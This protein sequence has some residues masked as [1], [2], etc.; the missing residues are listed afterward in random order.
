MKSTILR[1][2]NNIRLPPSHYYNVIINLLLQVWGVSQWA[3]AGW[4]PVQPTQSRWVVHCRG[5]TSCRKK[6]PAWLWADV[7]PRPEWKPSQAAKE[8]GALQMKLYL[9]GG[10]SPPSG[11][12]GDAFAVAMGWTVSMAWVKSSRWIWR[13]GRLLPCASHLKRSPPSAV[14]RAG[15][16]L[17]RQIGSASFV[18]QLSGGQSSSSSSH[19]Q[20]QMSILFVWTGCSHLSGLRCLT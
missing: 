15:T 2:P 1:T 9:R 12:R 5:R 6:I 13:P 4:S 14:S 16:A 8:A 10:P 20:L 17:G 7:R 19:Y 18:T 3:R 11:H